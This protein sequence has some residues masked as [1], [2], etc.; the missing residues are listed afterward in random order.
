M[1]SPTKSFSQDA[2]GAWVLATASLTIGRVLNQFHDAPLPLVYATK[3]ERIVQEA[4][5]LSTAAIAPPT[6]GEAKLS[7]SHEPQAISLA[8]FK[9]FVNAKKGL[10]LD[11]RPEIF[12]RLG[13]YR[14]RS[15]CRG[16]TSKGVDEKEKQL[17]ESQKKAPMAYRWPGLLEAGSLTGIFS[18]RKRH[19]Q[20]R[21][22]EAADTINLAD[23]QKHSLFSAAPR[24]DELRPDEHRPRAHAGAGNRPFPRK[25]RLKPEK[26]KGKGCMKPQNPL[27]STGYQLVF[28]DEFDADDLDTAKWVPVYL[29]QWSSSERSAPRFRISDGALT[30]YIANDQPPWCPE[31][32]GE[33]KCSCLQTGLF[34]GSL[35]SE[36]GQHRFKPGLI[37]REQQKTIQTYVPTYGYFELRA[38]AKI[39]PGHLVALWMI[40]FE[41]QPDRSG[42]ITI[43]EIFGDE[44]SES[45]VAVGHGIKPVN[46]PKLRPEFHKPVISLDLAEYHIFGAEWTPRGVEFFLDGERIGWTSQSPDYPMQ[47]MLTI[48]DLSGAN[49]P[50]IFEPSFTIDYFRGFALSE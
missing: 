9:Q 34:S 28:N 42:E 31:F 37:V 44:T 35:G 8:E 38:K 1:P 36:F 6:P 5:N 21:L 25:T 13:I 27:S 46:D 3:K 2:I 43:M 11:A 22:F 18:R 19:N 4:E 30:L 20:A 49:Q 14:A 32:D 48:Y 50:F 41:D 33:N 24:S 12:H 16:K 17:L 10:I 15:A 39:G 26:T 45:G 40:G 7:K 47:L 29:S 23:G